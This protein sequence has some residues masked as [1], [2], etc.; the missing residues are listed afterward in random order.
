MIAMY[1]SSLINVD[2]FFHTNILP[3]VLGGGASPLRGAI[4]PRGTCIMYPPPYL[5]DHG[6]QRAQTW[7]AHAMRGYLGSCGLDLLIHLIMG[8]GWCRPPYDCAS[9]SISHVRLLNPVRGWAFPRS[10]NC[11]TRH[12]SLLS[13]GHHVARNSIPYRK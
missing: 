1:M 6:G 3:F 8:C 11:A 7:W 13:I 4:R 10:L 9:V 5:G 2:V 12:H